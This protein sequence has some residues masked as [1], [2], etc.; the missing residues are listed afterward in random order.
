[1]ALLKY[2]VLLI[3]PR[4]IFGEKRNLIF[5][6]LSVSFLVKKQFFKKKLDER[7]TADKWVL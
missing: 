6:L 2:K 7:N 1:M 4:S 3:K 5:I